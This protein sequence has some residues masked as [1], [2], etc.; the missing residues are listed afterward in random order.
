MREEK[1]LPPVLQLFNLIKQE[2]VKKNAAAAIV[3]SSKCNWILFK[4][5]IWI[6]FHAFSKASTAGHRKRRKLFYWL[7]HLIS[8]YL[9][10]KTTKPLQTAFL[11]CY[12]YLN[13]VDEWMKWRREVN[14]LFERRF[15]EM[16]VEHVAKKERNVL[17][18]KIKINWKN[19]VF[20]TRKVRK[21]NFKVQ[22]VQKIFECFSRLFRQLPKRFTKICGAENSF[23][24]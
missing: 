24:I 4:N 22:S 2:K 21:R 23:V 17:M 16:H 14:A 1:N 19:L 9:F 7:N 5:W 18:R 20:V 11:F 6:L 10:K 12:L 3:H 15:V 13:D 8:A